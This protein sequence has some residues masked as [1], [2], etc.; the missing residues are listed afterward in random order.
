[1]IL[2]STVCSFEVSLIRLFAE[3][4][5]GFYH[6]LSTPRTYGVA[7]AN[8]RSFVGIIRMLMPT[9]KVAVWPIFNSL[10][11][12][13]VMNRHTCS[14]FVQLIQLPASLIV[15]GETIFR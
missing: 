13:V 14:I 8:T 15:V 12:S 10:L 2:K 3:F 11:D 4:A 7:H 6:H 5:T 1:M 9:V